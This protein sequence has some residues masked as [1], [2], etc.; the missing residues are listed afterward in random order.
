MLQKCLLMKG[1]IISIN[2]VLF[3]ENSGTVELLLYFYAKCYILG[4]CAFSAKFLELFL[5][6]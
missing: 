5:S 2:S 6:I 1:E 3:V 4:M